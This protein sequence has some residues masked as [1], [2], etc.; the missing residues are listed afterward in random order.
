MEEYSK[1]EEAE[2]VVGRRQEFSGTPLERCIP[3]DQPC[4]LGYHCPVCDYGQLIAG[5]LNFDERLEW[6]EYQGFVWCSVCN[7]DYPTALCLP[8]DQVDRAI[9]IYLKCIENAI[10]R[11]DKMVERASWQSGALRTM[12]QVE[13]SLSSSEKDMIF[14]CGE[15]IEFI[16]SE[17]QRRGLK[18]IAR[19]DNEEVTEF[20]VARGET[21]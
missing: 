21:K 15:S 13:R 20:T 11:S 2:R 4:E 16:A 17:I 12:E 9:M 10:K 14:A 19:K 7:K 3:L 6:S 8:K 18:L 1:N 5:G